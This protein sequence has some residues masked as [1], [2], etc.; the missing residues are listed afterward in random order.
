M[1]FYTEQ[2]VYLVII[3]GLLWFAFAPGMKV[4][5]QMG[6][7]A[8]VC[9][10]IDPSFAIYTCTLPRACL[11]VTGSSYGGITVVPRNGEACSW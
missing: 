7:P 9:Q 1:K 4:E 5:A 10:Q 8:K 11:Y 6:K 3:F 2:A